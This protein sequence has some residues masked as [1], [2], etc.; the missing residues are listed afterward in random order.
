E[1]PCGEAG[2]AETH[3]VAVNPGGQPLTLASLVAEKQRNA[4]HRGE[5]DELLAEGV[6]AAVVEDDGRDDV[7]RVALA[8]RHRVQH[9]PVGAAIVAEVR[10][11]R[12]SPEEQRREAGGG[13]RKE[14]DASL[15]RHPPRCITVATTITSGKPTAPT[16]SSER[17]TS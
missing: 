1:Q 9:L 8:D 6:E 14:A 2:T 4:H 13:E 3:G 15:P 7:R 12:G 17:A 5:E 11:S 16:T 10:Q